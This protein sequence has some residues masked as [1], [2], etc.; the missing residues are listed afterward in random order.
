LTP[1]PAVALVAP[2]GNSNGGLQ[3]T[4]AGKA[5]FW[6]F[7]DKAPGQVNGNNVKDQWGTWTVVTTVK[8]KSSGGTTTTSPSSGG[9]SF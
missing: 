4:Y 7:K 9:V 1:G 3:V 5:L 8:P 6:F 2:L